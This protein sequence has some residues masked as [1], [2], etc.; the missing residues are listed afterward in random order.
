MLFFPD[1]QYSSM[2]SLMLEDNNNTAIFF[3]NETQVNLTS[4]ATISSAD[5]TDHFIGLILTGLLSVVLGL[6][7]LITVIGEWHWYFF[8][9]RWKTICSTNNK[10]EIVRKWNSPNFY[11]L[12]VLRFEQKFFVAAQKR[13]DSFRIFRQFIF[14]PEIPKVCGLS[15]VVQCFS[16]K[17]IW[18]GIDRGQHDKIK[19]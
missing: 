14:L 9:W 18:F 2:A 6:M 19:N 15:V 17:I 5:D 1:L 10:K 16:L 12:L 8:N 13:L 4:N 7:I 11:D 3:S